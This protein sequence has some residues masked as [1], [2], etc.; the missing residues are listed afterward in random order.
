MPRSGPVVKTVSDNTVSL[1]K[2]T[3]VCGSITASSLSTKVCFTTGRIPLRISMSDVN[4]DA[5]PDLVATNN[6]SN[7]MGN[8]RSER[9][10]RSHKCILPRKDD[11]TNHE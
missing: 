3:R 8:I 10:W 5:N 4:E 6:G 9:F 2:N 11:G 7:G 1:F